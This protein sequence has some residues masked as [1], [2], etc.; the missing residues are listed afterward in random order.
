MKYNAACTIYRMSG[1]EHEKK[2]V[3]QQCESRGLFIPASDKII[4][5]YSDLPVGQ[6]YSFLFI[7]EIDSILPEDKLVI[8]DPMDSGLEINTELYVTGVTRNMYVL[9]QRII[10]GVAIKK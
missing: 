6:S 8:I 9:G 1:N 2:Y 5:L 3:E 7:N 10:E 4:A